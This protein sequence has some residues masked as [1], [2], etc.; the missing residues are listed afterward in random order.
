MTDSFNRREFLRR[1]GLAG[2][3]IGGFTLVG[4]EIL[5]FVQ[6]VE[7]ATTKSTLAIASK[8]S[9]EIL[10]K[11]AIDGLGG[12]GKFV[13]KGNTV[14]IKPNLAW[15]RTPA[16]AANTNPQLLTGLIK[17]CQKAGASRIT[18]LD[19]TCDNSNS[20]FPI[21]GAK[22]ICNA[23]KVRLISADKKFMYK[24]VNIPKG[25]ILKSDDCAAEVLN[26][27]VFINVPI[28][29]VHG[30]ATIT[31]SMKNMMG[32][33]WDRQA[34]HTANLEQCIADYSTAVK[35]DLIILD[36]IRIMLTRG[37]KG[38]G[39]TKDVGQVIAGTDPVA[40]DAYAATLL[41]KKPQEIGHIKYAAAL[42]VGQMDLKKVTLRRV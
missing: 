36:A 3:A 12:I 23:T 18:V 24:R 22:D 7:A 31:A 19:H 20:A 39:E 42:G 11:K 29:K 5:G 32:T 14:L 10:V 38:P 1:A 4:D 15:A 6:E 37:P 16:Q 2:I 41:G 35:P 40:I 27:D 8:G 34:W 26:A 21:N 33:N 25:K 13:K 17:L 9:P 30:G 28:A